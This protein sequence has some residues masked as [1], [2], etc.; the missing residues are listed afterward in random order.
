MRKMICLIIET[1]IALTMFSGCTG[2]SALEG[3]SDTIPRII[4]EE[5]S[6]GTDIPAIPA[7]Q[8]GSNDVPVTAEQTA[9]IALPPADTD[10]FEV[11]DECVKNLQA[12][13]LDYLQLNEN[14][15]ILKEDKSTVADCNFI[16]NGTCITLEGSARRIADDEIKSYDDLKAIFLEHCTAD[17]ADFILTY[18]GGYT[19]IDGELYTCGAPPIG[20][21][22]APCYI[23]DCSLDGNQLIVDIVEMGA[24]NENL[25]EDIDPEFGHLMADDAHYSMTLV[26]QGDRWLISDCGNEHFLFSLGENYRS[27]LSEMLFQLDQ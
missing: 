2:Q 3:S 11:A 5:A 21:T 1:F 19:D 18:C 16:D 20:G 7:S 17:Y 8:E 13:Y 25:P 27:D 23:N 22:R 14:E 6:N 4:S 9:E 15:R 26:W 12:L 10:L 24:N